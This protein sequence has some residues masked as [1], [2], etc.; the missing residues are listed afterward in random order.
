MRLAIDR[1]EKTVFAASVP[2]RA[3]ILTIGSRTGKDRSGF[4]GQMRNFYLNG[5]EIALGQLA[6]RAL[7][8][9]VQLGQWG[10][11][12]TESACRNDGKCVEMYDSF[13]CERGQGVQ[14][15]PL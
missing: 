6:Q 14:G 1:A 11:C 9:G 15:S 2:P 8:N 12:A 4:A 13:R 5:D 3:S 10:A 7:G